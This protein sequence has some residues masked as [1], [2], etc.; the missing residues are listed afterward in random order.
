VIAE[1]L[2]VWQNTVNYLKLF[3]SDLHAQTSCHAHCVEM[4]IMGNLE[5]VVGKEADHGSN[6]ICFPGRDYL[7]LKYIFQSFTV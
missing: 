2:V 4:A 7:V 3:F 1:L 6:L 5:E